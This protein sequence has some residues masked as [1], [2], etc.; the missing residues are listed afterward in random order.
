MA[1]NLGD[2]GFSLT[3]NYI[4]PAFLD[5]QFVTQFTQF[6]DEGNEI[7]DA[8]G[9]PIFLEKRDDT[10]RVGAKFYLDTQ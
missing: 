2:V 8:N 5:D 10:A 7:T 4:G 1:Y 9:D 3:G 6:D